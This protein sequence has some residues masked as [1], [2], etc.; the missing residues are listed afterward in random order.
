MKIKYLR[1]LGQ[2][3]AD[4]VVDTDTESAEWLIARGHAEKV[5]SGNNEKSSDASSESRT[6]GRPRKAG[7]RK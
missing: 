4:T 5:S 1:R 3:K 2:N 6:P 7:D